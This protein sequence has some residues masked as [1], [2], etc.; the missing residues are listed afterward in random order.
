[1]DI[2]GFQSE[3]FQDW[4]AGLCSVI[5][6]GSCNFRCPG[7]HA[8]SLIKQTQKFDTEEVIK[9]L[10]RK[11]AF[12]SKVVICGGEPTLESDLPEFIR[13]LKKMDFAV[14]LDTNGSNPEVIQYLIQQNLVDYIAMDVKSCKELYPILTGNT[15]ASRDLIS[16]IEKSLTFIAATGKE[17]YELRTTVFPITEKEG[18]RWMTPEEMGMMCSWI[19]EVTGKKDHSHYLQSFKAREGKVMIDSRFGKEN[20]PAEY[21]ETPKMLLE[22]MQS[23]CAEKGYD[24]EIR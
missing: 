16:R 20:L 17:K 2:R 4:D 3:S 10:D 9:R 23:T 13:E 14:K 8:G 15:M 7:C 11:R 6:T 21:H 22:Q 18:V 1:M 12:V 5:Y 24:L 19:S